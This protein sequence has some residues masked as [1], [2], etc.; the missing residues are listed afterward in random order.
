M[1]TLEGKPSVEVPP[2]RWREAI[3]TSREAA[4]WGAG[5]IGAVGV[6]IFG[7]IPALKGLNFE[8]GN[9]EDNSQMWFAL[10]SALVGIGGVTL[11]IVLLIR[12]TLPMY[13]S[14]SRI[15]QQTR[16]DLRRA[17]VGEFLPAAY[18]TV[19]LLQ[20]EIAR[21]EEAVAFTEQQARDAVGSN[22]TAATKVHQDAVVFLE[23]LRAWATRLLNYDGFN[24]TQRRLVGPVMVIA[25]SATALGATC[26]M[27]ATS[28]P[29]DS[30]EDTVPPPEVGQVAYLT[31][32]D[33]A[34]W[35]EIT[36]VARVDGCQ[37]DQGRYLVL[38]TG[39]ADDLYT[40][41]TLPRAAGICQAWT[42]DVRAEVAS[43]NVLAEPRKATIRFTP[44]P[45][46]AER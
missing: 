16:R 1:S 18:P 42:F 8:W 38:V 26:F 29:A 22:K 2:D 12:A 10:A 13:T 31:P 6:A 4:K 46:P 32:L 21:R 20:Q 43:V 3:T 17:A 15:S 24:Q 30:A 44:A 11:T 23:Q 28:N 19:E 37:D 27:F 5:A 36:S 39:H 14:L 40:V 9:L 45:S 41:Q 7:G 25:I 33:A 35:A 34:A